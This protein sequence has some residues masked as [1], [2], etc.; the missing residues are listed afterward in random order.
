MGVEKEKQDQVDKH[1]L[2]TVTVMLQNTN[3]NPLKYFIAYLMLF[4]FMTINS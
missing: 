4:V 3:K 2:A 1:I